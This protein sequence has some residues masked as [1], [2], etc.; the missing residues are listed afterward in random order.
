MIELR[1]LNRF[2][3]FPKG[4]GCRECPEPCSNLEPVPYRCLLWCP[5]TTSPRVLV[6]SW[7]SV[8]YFYWGH[9]ITIPS[10]S[11]PIW[12]SEWLPC[13]WSQYWGKPIP[14]FPEVKLFWVHAQTLNDPR[15]SID[16]NVE[17]VGMLG[18]QLLGVETTWRAILPSSDTCWDPNP[19]SLPFWDRGGEEVADPG[20]ASVGIVQ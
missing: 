14:I 19:K 6:A 4:W 13:E 20:P 12:H 15:P 10:G 2:T 8:T 18:D 11:A 9:T 7:P 3:P 5:G 16:L 1:K 17:H